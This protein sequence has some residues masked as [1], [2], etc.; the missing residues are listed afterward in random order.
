MLHSR[1]GEHTAEV[2]AECLDQFHPGCF[3][4]KPAFRTQRAVD[5]H[6]ANPPDAPMGLKIRNE[7][8]RRGLFD[9]IGQVI[10]LESPGSQG[11]A[12]NPRHSMQKTQSFV[13]LDDGTKA[14]LNELYVDY[15]YRRHEQFW[16]DQAMVKLPAIKNAT[17][18][19]IC[20]EDLGMV[21]DCV[22]GVMR[23]L[24]I[25][26]LFI[27]RMPK[28]PKREFFHPADC[29]YL[30]VCTPS[31]HDMSTLRGWWEEDRGKTQ[32]FYH[33]ILGH[34]GP[35]PYFCEPWICREIV[36]QHLYSP[37]MWAV[38]PIQDLLGMSERLRRQDPREERIN[39]PS[40]PT[41]F[42]KYRLHVNVEDLIEEAE[43]NGL[44]RQM[45]ADAGRLTEC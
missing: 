25:L 41:H 8:I 13:E 30:S 35:A 14:K 39:V 33:A 15:F 20:G 1:F 6:L 27:Q 31:S 22:E 5:A 7:M 28:D 2:V 16:R 45:I 9:L 4:L 26:S 12:F 21:P 38:F 11:N 36:V 43:F 44:L 40:N 42:W 19:L 37:S 3:R 34:E 10:L 18:M 23:D 24:S 29:P 32:R 17:N